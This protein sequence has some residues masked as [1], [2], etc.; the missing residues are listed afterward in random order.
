M[1][2]G[3]I[4]YKNYTRDGHDVRLEIH[5]REAED[6]GSAKEIGN[7]TE[8]TIHS[9]ESHEAVDAPIHKSTLTFSMVDAPDMPDSETTKNSG[10]ELF[11]NSDPDEY[12]VQV[13]ED[14]VLLWSGN[15]AQDAWEGDLV[16]RNTVTITCRDNLGRLNELKYEKRFLAGQIDNGMAKVRSV[17]EGAMD[18]A[19]V[20]MYNS[21]ERLTFPHYLTGSGQSMLD[22]AVDVSLFQDKT[23][24]E[25]LEGILNSLGLCIRYDGRGHINVRTLRDLHLMGKAET[26]EVPVQVPQFINRSGHFSLLPGY[27][28]VKESTSFEAAE[29][30]MDTFT[31][32]DFDWQGRLDKD[33]WNATDFKYNTYGNAFNDESGNRD[34]YVLVR[35]ISDEY[36]IT[37]F[38]E[39]TINVANRTKVRVNFNLAH[40]YDDRGAHKMLDPTGGLLYQFKWVN[41]SLVYYWDFVNSEWT[42]TQ[43]YAGSGFKEDAMDISLEVTT[44]DS[45]GRL[46]FGFY[47]SYNSYGEDEET[48]T[49]MGNFVIEVDEA[50]FPKAINVNTVFNDSNTLT[51]D[52][53]A[54]YGQAPQWML[55]AGTIGNAFYKWDPAGGFPPLHTCNWSDKSDALPIPVQ[56]HMQLLA[57]HAKPNYVLTGDLKALASDQIRMDG[58]WHVYD[59][60]FVLVAANYNCLDGMLHDATLEEFDTWEDIFGSI[61]ASYDYKEGE[62][63]ASSLTGAT[64]ITATGGGGQGGDGITLAQLQAYLTSNHYINNLSQA[65]IEAALGFTP[66]NAASVPTVVSDLTNDAGYVKKTEADTW[67]LKSSVA[68]GRYAPKNGSGLTS[69]SAQYFKVG[70]SNVIYF[71]NA[72]GS[73]GPQISY[74]PGTDSFHINRT[75]EVGGDIHASNMPFIAQYDVTSYD[76]LDNELSRGRIVLLKQSELVATGRHYGGIGDVGVEFIFY[77]ALPDSAS[78][79]VRIVR[80]NIN[81]EWSER[82]FY[83]DMHEVEMGG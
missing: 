74:T 54:E 28:A 51:L 20:N 19:K 38:N 26:A 15:V 13:Y 33:K 6:D 7:F 63:P 68:D 72:V 83:M 16:Y 43:K 30:T 80:C 62:Y 75:L 70:I 32:D 25:I 56:V 11:Y 44:P 35:T 61:S 31:Q 47:L 81:N 71:N 10:W 29:P 9:N 12:S 37:H 66:A 64:S 36:T 5:S 46:V 48:Y 76:D 78:V 67:Y 69:F 39:R 49:R 58:V 73:T 24:H 45:Q 18:A 52:R 50:S 59:R 17:I 14:D 22:W 53:K 3:L 77:D 41:G 79:E 23:W 57:L 8:L 82:V 40:N 60:A 2:Y 55:S 21:R 4:F 65:D 34:K 42:L 1:S 27:K